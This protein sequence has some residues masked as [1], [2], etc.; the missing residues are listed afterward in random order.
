MYRIGYIDDEP[1]HYEKFQKKIQ[2]RFKDVE[3]VFIDNCKTKDEFVDK[4]YEEQVDV[5]LVDYKMV[6][7]FGFNGS[8]LINY[9]NDEVRD[10]ECFVLTA[11]DQ[12]SINDGLVAYRNIRSKSIFD[13]EGDDEERVK[14]LTDFIEILKESS[15]VYKTRR[16][17]NKTKYLNLLEKKKSGNISLIEEEELS[18]LYRI[19]SSYGLI[20]KL[21]NKV[22]ES[23]FE[24]DLNELL[25]I[26][27]KILNN[28]K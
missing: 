10:L 1:K 11:V 8:T 26:G 28:H 25:K 4:I 12:D 7:T 27:E 19:L 2:R 21:P 23:E 13:T 14:Q 15:K 18:R 5:L 6:G 9:I 20:E 3:L 22:L 16:E 24:K 17:E